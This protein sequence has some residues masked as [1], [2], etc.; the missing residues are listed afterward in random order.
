MGRRP[1]LDRERLFAEALLLVDEEGAEALTVTRLARR[2]G[3]RAASLYNHVS[4]RE[5]IIEGIRDLV[6]TEMDLEALDA[7]H[8][9]TALTLWARSYVAAFARHPNTI[10]LLANTTIRSSLTLEMYER[11]V[12]LLEGAGWPKDR[13]VAVFTAVESFAIGS[14]LDLVAPSVMIDPAGREVPLLSS[15]LAGEHPE[16]AMEAF[17]LGLSALVAG[18]VVLQ[19]DG[20]GRLADGTGDPLDHLVAAR[21]VRHQLDRPEL[22]PDREL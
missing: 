19:R 3:V 20:D 12:S 11:A 1:M 6:V 10:R 8:W 9:P 4:G 22:D 15:A 2:L 18:L 14:A 7:G 5:E 17:D 21:H 16:R 13:V